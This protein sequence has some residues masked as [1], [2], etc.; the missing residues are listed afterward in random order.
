LGILINLVERSPCNQDR[1]LAT[2]VPSTGEDIFTQQQTTLGALID[3]FI[4]K[5]ESARMEEARTD[6]ILDGK[7]PGHQQESRS[8]QSNASGP[9]DTAASAGKAQED[10]MEETVKKCKSIFKHF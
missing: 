2:V 7:P 9:N 3:L 10:A 1:L 8:S 4:S 6:E 5:E